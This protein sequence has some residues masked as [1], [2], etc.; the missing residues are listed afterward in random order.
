MNQARLAI[1]AWLDTPLAR[2]LLAIAWMA[3][4]F[5]LSSQSKLPSP[6][7]PWI[8][9]LFK[10]TAHFTVFGIL[11]VLLWRALPR[12]PR[13]WLWAWLLTALYAVS[14]EFHQVFVASRTPTARDVII[15][16]CGAATALAL[17]WWL[18]RRGGIASRS[19][20]KD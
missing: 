11:A 17:V 10:K 12:A 19:V 15:D 20:Q 13:S 3:L 18:R 9:F 1:P 6:D 16:M 4:I 2:W 8:N 5:A 7:D 14:D